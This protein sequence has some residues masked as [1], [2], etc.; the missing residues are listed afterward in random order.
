MDFFFFLTKQWL[1]KFLFTK[2]PTDVPRN[3]KTGRRGYQPIT[4]LTFRREEG[5]EAWWRDL[6]RVPGPV[7]STPET[8]PPSAA[9]RPQCHICQKADHL[10]GHLTNR[11]ALLPQNDTRPP[12]NSIGTKHTQYHGRDTQGSSGKLWLQ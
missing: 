6:L 1:K 2:E 10:G 7:G 8:G 3:H 12:R 4:P 11:S 5:N 9:L